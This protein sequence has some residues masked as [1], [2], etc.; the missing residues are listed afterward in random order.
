[1]KKFFLTFISVTFLLNSGATT[2]DT[3]AVAPIDSIALTRG[4]NLDDVV[5]YGSRNNFG[6]TSS[7]MS[8]VTLNKDQ[9]HARLC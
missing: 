2:I 1:M 6:V 5:V 3:T 7:Q 9:I 4:V 8:A